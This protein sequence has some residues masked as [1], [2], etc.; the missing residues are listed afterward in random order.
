M[1][2][3]AL[4]F[5]TGETV[6]AEPVELFDTD[7]ERVVQTFDNTREFQEAAKELLTSVSGR[8]LELNPSLAHALIVK[9]PLVPPQPLVNRQARI[10]EKISEIFVIMPKKGE[11]KPWM[12]LHTQEYETLVVEFSKEVSTLKKLVQL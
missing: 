8:V 9:I 12:I 6:A 5:S 2:C 11:R 3:L 7:K 4:L 10:E 1:L